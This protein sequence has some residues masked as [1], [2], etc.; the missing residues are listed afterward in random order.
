[1]SPFEVASIVITTIV[2]QGKINIQLKI[3]PQFI[4]DGKYLAVDANARGQ[5]NYRKRTRQ[6]MGPFLA[7]YPYADKSKF[8]ASINFTED[9]KATAEIM[10]KA[11]PDYLKSVF[12]SHKKYWP[13]AMKQALGM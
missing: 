13:Q 6:G 11:G 5:Q 4:S 3:L 1:M 2:F 10:Y 9:H 8:V 7:K 12:G